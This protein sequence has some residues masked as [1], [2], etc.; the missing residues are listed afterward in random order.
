M[1]EIWR[2][3]TPFGRLLPFIKDL[4]NLKFLEWGEIA[5]GSQVEKCAFWISSKLHFI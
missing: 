3:M 5:P 2:V 4:I 1:P